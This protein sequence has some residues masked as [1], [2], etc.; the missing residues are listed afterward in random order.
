MP[1]TE[2]PRL[3]HPRPR[4]AAQ[5]PK[6]TKIG[7]NSQPK[8]RLAE[9]LLGENHARP[10]Q[11][12]TINHHAKPRPRSKHPAQIEN[13]NPQTRRDRYRLELMKSPRNGLRRWVFL[14]GRWKWRQD[15]RIFNG[16]EGRAGW[17]K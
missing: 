9:K 1:R 17:R 16:G 14:R 6:S 7:A 11:A 4:S 5:K 13:G 15:G 8:P 10:G 2:E 3:H 12:K